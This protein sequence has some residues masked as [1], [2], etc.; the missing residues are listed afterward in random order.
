MQSRLERVVRTSAYWRRY[1]ETNERSLL[2]IPWHAGPELSEPEALAIAASV[3]GFQRGES[4]EGT[5]LRRYARAWAERTGDFDYIGAVALFI[6]EEQ[7]HARD[8]GRFLE[9]NDIPLQEKNAPDRVF[10]GLRHL[11]GNLEV[12]V[13]V[14][15]TAEIIAKVYYAGLKGATRSTVLRTLCDQILS[16]EAKHVEFQ[17]EQLG[18]LQVRRGVLS[19]AIVDILRRVLFCGTCLVVWVFHRRA[20]QRGNLTFPSFRTACLYELRQSMRIT[21]EVRDAI[22]FRLEVLRSTRVGFV[23]RFQRLP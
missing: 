10:R 20:L 22:R 18:K 6:A 15:L 23:R 14:L 1:F 16:D 13:S 4:S 12:A 2:E 9:L 5:R 21:A 7:R 3:Q 17:S 19:Q 8:L 11:L